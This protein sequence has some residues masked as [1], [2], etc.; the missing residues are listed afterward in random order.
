MPLAV[1]ERLSIPSVAAA[2]EE[3]VAP[4]FQ[5]EA[6]APSARLQHWQRNLVS[7]EFR[8]GLKRVF[9]H[10]ALTRVAPSGKSTSENTNAAVVAPA[11]E[12]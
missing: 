9:S 4:D 2:V 11:L 5:L 6:I 8:K 10:E 12:V 7:P 3:R 1:A